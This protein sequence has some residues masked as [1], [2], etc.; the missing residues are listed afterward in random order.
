M[1]VSKNFDLREFIDPL[2]YQQRGDKSIQLIDDRIIILAQFVRDHF[3]AAVTIND[4]W[5]GGHYF[6]SGLRRWDTTT[7]AELSQHKFGRA[8]DI[9]VE[10]IP[11]MNVRDE[12]RRNWGVFQAAGLTC[13]E[14]NTPTWTHLDCRYT[15]LDE[16]LEIP[17]R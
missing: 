15:G 10:G 12:I 17:Y 3:N 11:P 9:K 13:I 8:I 14:K 6:E 7:G 5:K 1:K 4:Y 2:T 16:L